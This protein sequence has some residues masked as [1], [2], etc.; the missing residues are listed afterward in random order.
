MINKSIYR[1]NQDPQ[2]IGMPFK[3]LIIE[4]VIRD[5]GKPEYSGRHVIYKFSNGYGLS[6]VMGELFYTDEEHPYEICPLLHGKLCY[7]ALDPENGDVYPR[8]TDED[9]FI[10]IA[11][12]QALPPQ[13]EEK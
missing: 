10:M 4:D 12:L 8:Q 6:V 1:F 11:K 3:E 13:G 7:D 5:M 2:G 9:L